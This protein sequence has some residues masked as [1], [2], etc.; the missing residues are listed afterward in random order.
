MTLLPSGSFCYPLFAIFH[1]K[2]CTVPNG[3]PHGNWF[4][5]WQS[6][7]ALTPLLASSVR[8]QN[9]STSVGS[10]RPAWGTDTRRGRLTSPAHPPSRLVSDRQRQ[11]THHVHAPPSGR[12]RDRRRTVL[13]HLSCSRVGQAPG[14]DRPEAAKLPAR[15]C[16]S[17]NKTALAQRRHPSARRHAG[18]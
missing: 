2:N 9:F 7:P 3:G 13:S 15:P 17:T 1:L 18:A 6:M 8:M 4:A 5:E 16:P 10:R 14:A 12:T 11:R